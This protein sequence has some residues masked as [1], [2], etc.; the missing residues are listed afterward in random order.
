MVFLGLSSVTTAFGCCICFLC[1]ESKFGTEIV[2]RTMIFNMSRANLTIAS[3][4]GTS[5]IVLSTAF[6]LLIEGLSFRSTK[7]KTLS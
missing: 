5:K 3:G 2:I 7:M 4:Q 1:N 6:L